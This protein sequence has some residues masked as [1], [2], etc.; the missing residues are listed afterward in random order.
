MIDSVFIM[1]QNAKR[2]LSSARTSNLYRCVLLSCLPFVASTVLLSC[3]NQDARQSASVDADRASAEAELKKELD[4]KSKQQKIEQ[5]RL[6]QAAQQDAHVAIAAVDA[7]SRPKIVDPELIKAAAPRAW[8]SIPVPNFNIQ[9]VF[10]STWQNGYLNYRVALLGD[11]DAIN[12]FLRSYTKY[13]IVLANQGGYNVLVFP[14]SPQSF[15]WRPDSYNQG[16]PTVDFTSTQPCSLEAY[17]D[18]VQ[19][20]LTWGT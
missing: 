10:N 3:A 5:W 14:I 20:N 9:A 11:R 4:E 12:D 17:E 18:A 6:K 8:A 2:S 15:A 13:G 1:Q 19:W 16:I 7:G